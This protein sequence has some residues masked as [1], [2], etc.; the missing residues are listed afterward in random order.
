M[1]HGYDDQGSRFGPDGN[2]NNWW[3][4]ADAKAFKARTDKLVKQ[5]DGYE[6]LPGLHV[7]GYQTLG[8]NIADLGGLNIAY[9]AMQRAQPDSKP[10]TQVDGLTRDQRFFLGFGTIWRD[11]MTP[12]YLKVIVNSNEHAPGEF[13]AIGAPSNMPAF[14][15]AFSCKAGD[16]MVRSGDKQV[17]IW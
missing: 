9:D 16:P 10:T 13:R 15:A 1:T 11:Q 6:A 17:V 4:D 5:F 2:F 3:T 12:D 7:K 8:E 14:A